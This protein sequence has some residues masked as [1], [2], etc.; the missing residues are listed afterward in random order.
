MLDK[1]VYTVITQHE[2][3]LKTLKVAAKF[4]KDNNF[5]F[6]AIKFALSLGRN[7]LA[8]YLIID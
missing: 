6:E 8:V 3:R 4:Q 1:L 2:Q 5:A 7:L